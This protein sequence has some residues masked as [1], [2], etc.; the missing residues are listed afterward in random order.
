M[1]VDGTKESV[2]QTQKQLGGLTSRCVEPT[3]LYVMI[4]IIAVFCRYDG[5]GP[6]TA[7]LQPSIHT[8]G[9][10]T[11]RSTAACFP[12]SRISRPMEPAPFE[13]GRCTP[14]NLSP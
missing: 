14:A 9:S 3:L 8:S 11:R 6:R 13:L 5:P 10:Y 2:E 4:V 12:L 1:N 7:V